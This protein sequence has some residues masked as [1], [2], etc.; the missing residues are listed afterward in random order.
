MLLAMKNKRGSKSAFV[1]ELM[2][3]TNPKECVISELQTLYSTA[4]GSDTAIYQKLTP[5]K[6][7]AIEGMA[8]F[9]YLQK[10][11]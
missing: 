2:S 6:P 7:I 11:P 10:Q 9:D 5:I 4:F 8:E 3:I 1:D